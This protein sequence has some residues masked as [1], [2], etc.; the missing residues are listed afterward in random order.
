MKIGLI[1]NFELHSIVWSMCWGVDNIGI[2]FGFFCGSILVR[3]IANLLSI[4]R[5]VLAITVARTFTIVSRRN[6]FVLPLIVSMIRQ[7]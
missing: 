3:L 2:L 7:P 1:G 5:R 4:L 6:H